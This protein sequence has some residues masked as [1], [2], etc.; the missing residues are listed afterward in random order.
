MIDSLVSHLEQKR[1]NL[2]QSRGVQIHPN[3]IDPKINPLVS[4]LEQKRGVQIHSHQT[5]PKWE[6]VVDVA[7]YI[8]K[9][10][11]WIYH[12]IRNNRISH[13]RTRCSSSHKNILY[14]N[15]K[16]VIAMSKK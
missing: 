11:A 16:E 10:K 7:Q 2:D 15:R 9:S 3:Q 13:K 1:A 12:Q 6:K 5:E 8:D 4:H 14:V